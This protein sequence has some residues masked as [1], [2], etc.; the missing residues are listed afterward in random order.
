VLSGKVSDD[1]LAAFYRRADLFV[2]LSVHEGFCIPVVEAMAFDVPVLATA[3][4]ALPETIGDAGLLLPPAP[5]ATL[6]AEAASR[7][8]TDRSLRAELI[9]NGRRRVDDH[10]TI[11]AERDFVDIALAAAR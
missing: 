5:A 2:T 9:E 8:L 10:A 11:G 7:L 6:V 4:A 3:V 1:T